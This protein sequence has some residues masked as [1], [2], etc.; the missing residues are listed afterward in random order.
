LLDFDLFA[1]FAP[2]F[3]VLADHERH[4]EPLQV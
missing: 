2:A 3:F 1:Q 4:L